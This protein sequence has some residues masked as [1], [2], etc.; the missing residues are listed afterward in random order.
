M[1]SHKQHELSIPLR[2]VPVDELRLVGV[3][4]SSR[5]PVAMLAAPGGRAVEVRRGV[6]VG[7]AVIACVARVVFEREDPLNPEAVTQL[8]TLAQP[9]RP[10][11]RGTFRL[12]SAATY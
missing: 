9:E 12:A 8:F 2:D 3:I 11:V 1:W 10:A 7:R 6:P 4:A 5:G